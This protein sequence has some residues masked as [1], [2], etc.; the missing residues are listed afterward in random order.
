MHRDRHPVPRA[1]CFG[2][3]VAGVGFD[4]GHTTRSTTDENRATITEHRD[5]RQDVLIRAPRVRV[6]A[7]TSEER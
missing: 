3:K 1:G 6:R 4:A 7:T 2:C 5:G